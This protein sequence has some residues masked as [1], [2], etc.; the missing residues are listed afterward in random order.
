MWS[1]LPH[2]LKVGIELH[3]LKTACRLNKRFLLEYLKEASLGLFVSN[4]HVSDLPNCLEHCQV[5]MYAD[6]TVIHFKANSPFERHISRV[7][8][9]DFWWPLL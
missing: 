7:V 1:G 2:T 5:V 3:V 6:G 8:S 9:R 4:I